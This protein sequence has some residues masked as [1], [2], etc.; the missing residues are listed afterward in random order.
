MRRT[1]HR[2]LWSGAL[3]LGGFAG[4]ISVNGGWQ[5]VAMFFALLGGLVFLLSFISLRAASEQPRPTRPTWARETQ[6]RQAVPAE[7]PVSV[8]TEHAP[9]PA[10]PRR[11]AGRRLSSAPS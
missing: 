11:P 9:A 5:P 1:F 4:M 10:P 3:M 8:D 7:R 2:F 6:R